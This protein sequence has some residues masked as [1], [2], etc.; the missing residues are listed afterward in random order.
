MGVKAQRG[1]LPELV[2]ADV[3]GHEDNGIFEID[4]FAGRVGQVAVLEDLEQEAEDVGVGFLNLVEEDDRVGPASDEVGQ[5]R[6]LPVADV[7]GRRADQFRDVEALGELGHVNS[8]QSVGIVK[9]GRGQHL[10]QLGFTHPGRPQEH[11]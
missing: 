11:E 10:G 3:R 2:R 7:A 9:D 1:L 6:A 5:L 4:F 8:N